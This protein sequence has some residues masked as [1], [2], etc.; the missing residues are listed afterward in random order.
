MP[1]ANIR[2]GDPVYSSDDKRLGSVDRVI[3]DDRRRRVEAII[4]HKLLRAG[5]KIIELPL[6]DRIE[7]KRIVL[8]IDAAEAEN[9]PTF[10]KES[11]IEIEPDAA[12]QALWS[13]LM[14]SAPGAVLAWAPVAGRQTV[15]E[16]LSGGVPTAIPHSAK[17]EVERNVPA[18]DDII[19][20]GTDVIDLNG[21]KVGSVAEVMLDPKNGSVAGFVIRK[22]LAFKSDYFIPS[23]WIDDIGEKRITLRVPASQV[24]AENRPWPS[25]G[26]LAPAFQRAI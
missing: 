5:D 17:V 12:Q 21:E 14:P 22:G 24:E 10:V 4:V 25:L 20:Y 18:E 9:L 13:S 23:E 26:A 11:F 1:Q 2:L 8:R 15:E 16:A 19:G 7:E 3:L 6:I